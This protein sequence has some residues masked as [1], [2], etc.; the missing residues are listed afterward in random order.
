MFVN[1]SVWG[2]K[3]TI[4]HHFSVTLTQECEN[5]LAT[6]WVVIK[7]RHGGVLRINSE[8]IQVINH[9]LYKTNTCI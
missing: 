5:N 8:H 6:R 3:D 7:Q 1:F 4:I 9:G 2:L